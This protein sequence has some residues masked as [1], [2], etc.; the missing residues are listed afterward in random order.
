[1]VTVFGNVTNVTD[2][3]EGKRVT[4]E[5]RA[6]DLSIDRMRTS[7]TDVRARAR[8][9]VGAGF[10]KEGFARTRD[11]GL[12]APR[13]ERRTEIVDKTRIGDNL[14][15]YTIIVKPGVVLQ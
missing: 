7:L 15:S 2:L 1:M 12:E 4:V 3:D 10:A 11:L 14:W 6:T 8:A 9:M 5:I 13:I